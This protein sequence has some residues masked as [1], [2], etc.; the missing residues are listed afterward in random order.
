ML[1]TSRLPDQRAFLVRR[2][3]RN[4]VA[5]PEV[6]RAKGAGLVVLMVEASRACVELIAV[7]LFG[8][9]WREV[10]PEG[11]CHSFVALSLRKNSDI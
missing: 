10:I 11:N 3:A 8:L 1:K 6:D 7:C 4:L 5:I 9:Q 2:L